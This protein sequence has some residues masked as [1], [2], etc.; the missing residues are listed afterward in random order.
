M[1]EWV[2]TGGRGL[3]VAIF[4]TKA[5]C[6]FKSVVG[7]AKGIISSIA[8]KRR[9]VGKAVRL[10]ADGAIKTASLISDTIVIE[11][12]I[13]KGFALMM[14]PSKD[15]FRILVSP[16]ARAVPA[17]PGPYRGEHRRMCVAFAT[18]S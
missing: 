8:Y 14:A 15:V 11:D 3:L 9:D 2:R 18:V 10:I 17:M 5:S 12:G 7:T 13:G 16:R 4:T 1:V 6:D